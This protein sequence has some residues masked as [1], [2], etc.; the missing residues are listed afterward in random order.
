MRLESVEDLDNRVAVFCKSLL[1]HLHVHFCA[2]LLETEFRVLLKPPRGNLPFADA[3][4]NR[5]WRSTVS[6]ICST[7]FGKT[8]QVVSEDF[9]SD[10]KGLDKDL[11]KI[12][13][14]LPNDRGSHHP[15]GL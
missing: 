3:A 9:C 13:G 10:A 1:G 2:V 7:L 12:N 4:E 8:R 14:D 6:R 11:G 15:H 5:Q